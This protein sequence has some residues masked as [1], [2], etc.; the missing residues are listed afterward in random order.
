MT[1]AMIPATG[2]MG[3]HPFGLPG[4]ATVQ[5]LEIVMVIVLQNMDTRNVSPGQGG[6]VH[7]LPAKKY[8]I[9]Q[10]QGI[11]KNTVLKI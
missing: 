3:A 11:L 7:F 2:V 1:P 8:L 9:T 5:K 4:A 6:K 10:V